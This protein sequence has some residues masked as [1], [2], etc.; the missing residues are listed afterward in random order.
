MLWMMLRRLRSQDLETRRKAFADATQNRN[1][2]TLLRV[3]EDADQYVR[4]DAIDALGQIGNAMAVPALIQRLDDANF[5][6]QEAAA[7][8]LVRIGDGRAVHPLVAMLRAVNKDNQA[9]FA[10]A[11]A[12]VELGDSKVV[13]PL[14]DALKDTDAFTRAR[15]LEVLAAI[16]DRRC[17][18]AAIAALRDPDPNVRWIAVDALG[19]LGDAR[20]VEP[21]LG[22][23]PHAKTGPGPS[24]ETIVDSLRR[25]GDGRAVPMLAALLGEPEARV[26]TAAA[27]ALD[28]L[29][30]QPGDEAA[31]VRYFLAQERWEELAQLGWERVREP[32]ME[33]MRSPDESV[34]SQVVAALGRIDD[35]HALE[36]LIAA[37]QDKDEYVAAAAAALLGKRGDV[38]AC[39]PLIDYSLR[40]LPEG[41]Y[42]NDPTAPGGEQ[43]RADA[44]VGPLEELL[45][46][47]ATKMTAEDL[48][49]LLSLEDKTYHLRV[50]YD[51]PGYGYGADDFVVGLEF[52]RVRKLAAKESR[53][54]QGGG[55]S[56]AG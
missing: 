2:E 14:L 56:S 17:V 23:L 15:A 1:A 30:W 48:S 4:R 49:A 6:N 35:R 7:A 45:K 16:G 19:V 28:A 8:A 47:A 5:N 20:A 38:R 27:A 12:L 31:R 43:G 41:G 18:P 39:K 55:D 50:E 3:I 54:R 11:H 22:L 53:R 25:I 34:R 24:R 13:A 33:S 46:N 9:R 26:R 51:T 10:A 29:G 52:S 21:L 36:P 42:R 44:W 37:L 32:L 40:Y